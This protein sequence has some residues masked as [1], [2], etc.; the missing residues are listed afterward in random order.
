[1]LV[2][3]IGIPPFD[4]VDEITADTVVVMELSSHQL[5][6]VSHAPHIAVLLNLFQE[7]LDHY[8]TCLLYT[9]RCV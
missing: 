7:H 3:N 2:G 9:S 4:C 6:Y 1:M 8:Y 5:E